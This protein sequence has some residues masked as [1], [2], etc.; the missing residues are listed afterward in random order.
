MDED[1][2][3]RRAKLDKKRSSTIGEMVFNWIII[4]FIAVF[5]ILDRDYICIYFNVNLWLTVV[6]G[7]Y[8][9]DLI[10]NLFAYNLLI[11]HK[12]ESLMMFLIRFLFS[13]FIV[14][15]MI[16]GNF[17]YYKANPSNSTD[18]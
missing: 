3:E 18:C 4:I 8:L 6:M 2:R 10:L 1:E 16:Y 17:K 14:G 15:W 5:V 12:K 7:Y 11:K 13:F 9:F